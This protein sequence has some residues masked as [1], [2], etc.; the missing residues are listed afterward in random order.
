MIY[1]PT[2]FHDEGWAPKDIVDAVR[3]ISGNLLYV[4]RDEKTGRMWF[5]KFVTPIKYIEER[6]RRIEDMLAVNKILEY[7]DK[8]LRETADVAN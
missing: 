3:W 2:I 1:E 7:A 8:L 6:A 5:T 4:V